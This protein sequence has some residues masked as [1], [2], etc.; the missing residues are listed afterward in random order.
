VNDRGLMYQR[1]D[2]TQVSMRLGAPSCADAVETPLGSMPVDVAA[3][4]ALR[5]RTECAR[6]DLEGEEDEHSIGVYGG[7]RDL[8]THRSR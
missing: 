3:V 1:C 8:S 6:M 5:K 7:G 4:E 2:H